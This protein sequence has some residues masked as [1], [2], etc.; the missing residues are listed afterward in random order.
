MKLRRVWEGGNYKVGKSKGT[1]VIVLLISKHLVYCLN[2]GSRVAGRTFGYYSA[3]GSKFGQTTFGGPP[4]NIRCT[5][6]ERT[7]GENPKIFLLG[8]PNELE[9]LVKPPTI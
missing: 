8:N 7:F 1:V 9:K 2:S 5:F 4:T 6:A 3:S